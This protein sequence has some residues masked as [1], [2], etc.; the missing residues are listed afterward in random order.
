MAA[1][2]PAARGAPKRDT[3]SDA[4]VTMYGRSKLAS[5]QALAVVEVPWVVLRPPTVYGP[6]D[7]DN[8]LAIFKAAKYGIAGI[9]DPALRKYGTKECVMV[10]AA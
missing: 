9:D 6:R 7:R 3:S 5:E 2:G 1:G 8:L 4:P 10:F